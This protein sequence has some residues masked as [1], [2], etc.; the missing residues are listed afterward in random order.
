MIPADQITVQK[1]MHLW[2]SSFDGAGAVNTKE[3]YSM[4][5][6]GNTHLT[7]SLVETAMAFFFFFRYARPPPA[8]DFREKDFKPNWRISS[9]ASA[10]DQDTFSQSAQTTTTRREPT[11]TSLRR[12]TRDRYIFSTDRVTGEDW[13]FWLCVPELGSPRWLFYLKSTVTNSGELTD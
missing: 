10:A 12:L 6:K 9:S 1:T 2:I 11:T 7:K 13:Q 3:Y 4:A 8:R 5:V